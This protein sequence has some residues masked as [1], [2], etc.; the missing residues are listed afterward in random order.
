MALFNPAQIDPNQICLVHL[1]NFVV[2]RD[3]KELEPLTEHATHLLQVGRELEAAKASDNQY[4]Q[5]MWRREEIPDITVN[6]VT[7]SAVIVLERTHDLL[8]RLQN[9]YAT[10]SGANLMAGFVDLATENN[11]GAT[12]QISADDLGQYN[13]IFG[14]LKRICQF[15]HKFRLFLDRLSG[16]TLYRSRFNNGPSLGLLPVPGANPGESENDSFA[17]QVNP[18]FCTDHIVKQPRQ[19][20]VMGLYILNGE[21]SRHLAEVEVQVGGWVPQ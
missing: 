18:I 13:G 7:I 19:A 9:S 12:G 21:V 20:I 10:L 1:E 16:N 5:E 14:L 8:E 4:R 6:G 15:N 11:Y 2:L 3:L 17:R